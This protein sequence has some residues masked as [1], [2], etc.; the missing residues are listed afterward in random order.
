MREPDRKDH[1]N[2]AAARIPAQGRAARAGYGQRIRGV[3]RR[4]AESVD[5]LRC[6]ARSDDGARAAVGESLLHH[7][8]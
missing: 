3:D 4:A 7:R 6:V 8:R 1:R 5:D 2:S